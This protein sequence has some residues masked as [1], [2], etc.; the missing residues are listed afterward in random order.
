M[1]LAGVTTTDIANDLTARVFGRVSGGGTFA[2]DQANIT[3]TSADGA[4]TLN[5][6]HVGG[7][8]SGGTYDSAWSLLNQDAF[9]ITTGTAFT[10]AYATTRY[11]KYTFPVGYVPSGATGISATITH[12]YRGS[13]GG[14]CTYMQIYNGTTSIATKGSSTSNLS[15]ATSTTTDQVDAVSVPEIN[16]VAEG[17]AVVVRV[18]AKSSGVTTPMV[19]DQVKLQLTYVK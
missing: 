12:A 10:T 9:A 11:I 7:S 14:I 19:A 4:F 6:E 13:A 18:Y 2:V 15:C 8:N 16:T 1:A 17:N 3:G 5:Q